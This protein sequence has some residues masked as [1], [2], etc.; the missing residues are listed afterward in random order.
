[1]SKPEM[2]IILLLTISAVLGFLS[3][4]KDDPI[5]P[6]IPTIQVTAVGGASTDAMGEMHL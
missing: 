6:S 3:C 4:K 2:M 1:M 5:Q